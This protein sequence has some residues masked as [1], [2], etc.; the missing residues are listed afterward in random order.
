MCRLMAFYAQS[1]MVWT[2]LIIAPP[3][4]I[5]TLVS[6]KY[7]PVV[8]FVKDQEYLQTLAHIFLGISYYFFG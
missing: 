8:Y 1:L 7:F 2:E 6:I 5:Q 4:R 3:G